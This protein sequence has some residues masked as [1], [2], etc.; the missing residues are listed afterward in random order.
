MGVTSMPLDPAAKNLLD[1]LVAAG[2]PKVWQ[3]S[4][5]EAR[6]GISALAQAA[7]AKDVPISAASKMLHG[8]GLPAPSPIAA[9]RRSTRRESRCRRC[10]I[11]TAAAS[12]SAISTPMTGCAD[13]SPMRAAAD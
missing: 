2:R 6:E 7:D 4:P 10:S 8:P 1:L 3:V 11:S 12:S 13:S 5:A 9:T